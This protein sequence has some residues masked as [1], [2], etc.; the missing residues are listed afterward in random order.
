MDL[1]RLKSNWKKGKQLIGENYKLNQN[2]MESV[3][4]NQS[5]DTTKRLSRIFL[6]GITVQ[7]LTIVLMVINMITYRQFSDLTLLTGVSL[8]LVVLALSFSIN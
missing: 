4:K 2:E 6:M 1:E 8:I 7:S 5:N 3:I